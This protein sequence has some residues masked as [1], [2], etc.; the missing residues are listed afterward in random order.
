MSL[1]P[2]E[3][4]VDAALLE[5]FRA[6][7]VLFSYDRAEI[8]K[9]EGWLSQLDTYTVK[10]PIRIEGPCA[11]Y[12]G[13]YSPSRWFAGSGLC[14]MGAA[15]YSHSPLPEG[16]TVGRYCSIGKGLRFIDFAHPTEWVS[17]S[18]AF[19][20]P[21]N[22]PYLSP[23]YDALEAR[24]GEFTPTAYDPRRGLGY[25]V[26][27]HDVWIG[28]NVTLGLGVTIGTGAVIAAN[29]TVTKDVP[30]YAIVGGLPA[31]VLK[32]RFAPEVIEALLAS[33]WWQYAYYDFGGLDYTK[34]REFAQGVMAAIASGS[35]TPWKPDVVEL[36]GAADD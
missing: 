21:D 4:K 22:V 36:P 14:D 31:K 11:F 16:L 15:S 3:L 34:P 17:S 23:L 24:N 29:A 5:R 26:I 28:D 7:G 19:F 2:V 8:A 10:Q 13:P 33:E 25:P 32:Y 18:I 30:P 6:A 35:L 9:G 12:G 27:E 20:R 1:T